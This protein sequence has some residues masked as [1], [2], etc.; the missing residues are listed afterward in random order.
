MLSMT[1]QATFQH[2]LCSFNSI[3]E[4]AQDFLYFFIGMYFFFSVTSAAHTSISA[5]FLQKHLIHP[6]TSSRSFS[7]QSYCSL[8]LKLE[9]SF[10]FPFFFELLFI[11][12]WLCWVHYFAVHRLSQEQLP[13]RCSLVAMHRLFIVV[14]SPLWQSTQA[15][16]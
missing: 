2:S 16:R 11:F 9:C 14:S 4:F 1:D 3:S 6:S 7:M 5:L 15:I 10:P 13:A 12:F 8:S